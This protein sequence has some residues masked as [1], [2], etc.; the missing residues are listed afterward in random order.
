MMKALLH[1]TTLRPQ[2]PQP[3]LHQTA[4]LLP[5]LPLPPLPPVMLPPL[6]QPPAPLPAALLPSVYRRAPGG[7]EG[8]GKVWCL[9]PAGCTA[10]I[11]VLARTLQC[12]RKV[13]GRWGGVNQQSLVGDPGQP[14]PSHTFTRLFVVLAPLFLPRCPAGVSPPSKTL[15][16]FYAPVHC[17]CA[18]L[19]S[20]PGSASLTRTRAR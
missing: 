17:T 8:V 18:P 19:P 1:Q 6:P 12:E 11:S 7:C 9:P 3:L 5:L 13:G 16:R 20:R 4:L 15:P 2:L 14:H 10:S